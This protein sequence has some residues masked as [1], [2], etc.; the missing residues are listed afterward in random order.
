[1][2]LVKFPD[3]TDADMKPWKIA[4]ELDAIIVAVPFSGLRGSRIP[5][6]GKRKTCF[7]L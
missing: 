3:E 1:V 6:T 5:M 2:D 7:V 4:S